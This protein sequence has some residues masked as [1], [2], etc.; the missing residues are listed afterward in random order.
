MTDLRHSHFPGA[1]LQGLSQLQVLDGE[2]LGRPKTGTLGC[3]GGRPPKAARNLTCV[4]LMLPLGVFPKA[5]C[6]VLLYVL[7]GGSTL[8][9]LGLQV[10][11]PTVEHC[12]I[13][14]F[15]C[16]TLPG[17][18]LHISARWIGRATFEL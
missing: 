9:L 17:V 1:Q 10:V 13:R 12:H 14:Q 4:I 2:E 5:C 3:T 11:V 15:L 6:R 18:L 16:F 8:G 7:K